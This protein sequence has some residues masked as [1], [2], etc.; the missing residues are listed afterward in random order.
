MTRMGT[1]TEPRSACTGPSRKPHGRLAPLLVW[2]V[3]A[4][5]AAGPREKEQAV[6]P[7]TI[8]QVLAAH[9]DSLMTIP[10]VVGTAIG[11]CGGKRCI[12]V[13]L[14]DSSAAT[15]KRIPDRLEGYRVDVEVTGPFRA[16]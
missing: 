8:E 15:R 9:T 7:R 6:P 1:A 14:R 5:C 4:S 16:R 10:G 13:F 3:L 12:R 2:A 11:L